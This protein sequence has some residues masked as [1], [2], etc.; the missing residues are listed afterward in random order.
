MRRRDIDETT[1]RAH[2]KNLR[3]FDKLLSNN[4]I[5]LGEITSTATESISRLTHVFLLFHWRAVQWKAKE[6]NQNRALFGR[7]QKIIS[8]SEM[9]PQSQK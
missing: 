9:G 8:M 5:F 6:S 2:D 4:H 7:Q 1:Y 3:E